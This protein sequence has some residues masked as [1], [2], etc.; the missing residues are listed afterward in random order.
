LYIIHNAI[1]LLE[2]AFE[3]GAFIFGDSNQFENIV[4]RTKL[5]GNY[6]KIIGDEDFKGENYYKHIKQK[7]TKIKKDLNL[8]IKNPIKINRKY[9]QDAFTLFSK[10]SDKYNGMLQ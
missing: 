3:G 1:G 9:F 6:S 4:R 2:E 8:I 7:L 10:A 5:Y